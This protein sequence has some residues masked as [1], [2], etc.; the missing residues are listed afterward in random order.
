MASNAVAIPPMSP[1]S[2][3][4]S[5]TMGYIHGPSNASNP[6]LTNAKNY[7]FYIVRGGHRSSAPTM[8]SADRVHAIRQSSDWHVSAPLVTLLQ[9]TLQTIDDDHDADE[10]V[11]IRRRHH[12]ISR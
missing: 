6:S 11:A 10:I 4:H 5:L 7:L 2:L 3:A 8:V 12:A 1:S 9:L